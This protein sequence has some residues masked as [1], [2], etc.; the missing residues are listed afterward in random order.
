[1]TLKKYFKKFAALGLAVSMLASVTACSGNSD[2]TTPEVE[3]E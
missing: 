3:L 2:K 1:M